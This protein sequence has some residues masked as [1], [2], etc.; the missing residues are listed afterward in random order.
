MTAVTERVALAPSDA[1]APS[2]TAILTREQV[3][4]WLQIKS[5]RVFKRHFPSP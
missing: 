1:S 3:M 2:P 5:E 4:A